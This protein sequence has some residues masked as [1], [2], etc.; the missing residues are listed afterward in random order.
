MNQDNSIQRSF[1]PGDKWLT[2]KLYTGVKTSEQFL[3]EII[4]PMVLE[5]E[6]KD[7]IEKWF[8]I[9]YSDPDFHLRIRFL[10][11]DN[12]HI[13]WL[14]KY[15]S[16]ACR[17]YFNDEKIWK[18]QVDTY[19][20]EL[21][22]YGSS[23]MVLSE[24]IFCIDSHS[25]IEIISTLDS[26]E[27]DEHRWKIVLKLVDQLLNCFNY[28]IIHKYN[29]ISELKDVFGNEFGMNKPLKVQLDSKFRREREEIVIILEDDENQP[30][31]LEKCNQL[32]HDRIQPLKTVLN[33]LI[34]L[35]KQDQLDV[36]LD[37]I[38]KSY[39]HMLCNRFFRSR[40]RNHEFVIYYMLFKY[41]KSKVAIQKSKNKQ[42]FLSQL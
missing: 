11:K 3:M 28:S 33:S 7:I 36:V 18:V 31:Y 20:R 13:G 35:D 41:Y 30:D 37:R 9:R 22:R 19:N 8:F 10:L 29:L 15:F 42:V 40:Q 24:S 1:M 38:C 14:F 4:Q 12:N 2:Y 6:S 23:G 17:A 21:E 39:I 34:E 16:E 27:L 25:A 26:Y 32:I 5:L